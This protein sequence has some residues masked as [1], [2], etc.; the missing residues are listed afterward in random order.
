M[1]KSITPEVRDWQARTANTVLTYLFGVLCI[2][3][4]VISILV[5]FCSAP[6]Q[7]RKGDME[8]AKANRFV[9]ANAVLDGVTIIYLIFL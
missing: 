9:V 8:T 1:A 5:P 4:M 6:L 2:A 7:P 3:G